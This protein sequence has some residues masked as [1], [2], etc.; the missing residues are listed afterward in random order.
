LIL[1]ISTYAMRRVAERKAY[2][3]WGKINF[4]KRHIRL[5]TS[6]L[7]EEMGIW[8]STFLLKSVYA[9]DLINA[10]KPSEIDSVAL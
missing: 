6:V 8:I 1:D 10:N 9:Q 5:N 3:L 4:G 2:K 7:L